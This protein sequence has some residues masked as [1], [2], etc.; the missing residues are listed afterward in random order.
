MPMKTD[1]EKW[2]DY[3][4]NSY[5]NNSLLKIDKVDN[6]IVI[7]ALDSNIKTSV[8]FEFSGNNLAD[9]SFYSGISKSYSGELSNGNP[10]TFSDKNVKKI[11]KDWL[12][13]PF[14]TGWK[15]VE[16]NFVSNTPYKSYIYYEPEKHSP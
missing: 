7:C 5:G 1:R 14:Y 8:V 11:E 4:I 9:I 6:T 2:E 15:E 12:S 16:F 13:I 10:L 3:I